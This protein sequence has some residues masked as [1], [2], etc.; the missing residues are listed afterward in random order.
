MRA[1]DKRRNFKIEK[2]TKGGGPEM[3]GGLEETIKM[4]I[5]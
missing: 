5:S 3:K 4:G 2:K 1:E